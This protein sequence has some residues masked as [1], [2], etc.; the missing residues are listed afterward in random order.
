MPQN[1]GVQAETH[2]IHIFETYS[3]Q[4][5]EKLSQGVVHVYYRMQRRMRNFFLFSKPLD[6]YNYEKTIF[7]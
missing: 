2:S 5:L 6:I 1:S 7:L 4:P 3:I